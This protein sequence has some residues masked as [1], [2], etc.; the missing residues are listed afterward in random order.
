M[1]FH[2]PNNR[3]YFK[4]KNKTLI[5]YVLEYARDMRCNNDII[6]HINF[7]RMK[8]VVVYPFEVV[9]FEVN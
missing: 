6:Y 4:T 8:K 9:G 2:S 5:E 3:R 1:P 7:V